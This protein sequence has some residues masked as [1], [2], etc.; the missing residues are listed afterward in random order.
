MGMAKPGN[1]CL[2]TASGPSGFSN[3][4]SHFE[5]SI[6]LGGSGA[7]TEKSKSM[8]A[9]ENAP[10]AAIAALKSSR[11]PF[12]CLSPK[13]NDAIVARSASEK[14]G[15]WALLSSDWICV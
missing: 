5:G 15:S 9:G 10:K 3:E 11:V 8:S 13:M 14:P 6:F 7:E 4:S 2:K 1:R 12:S